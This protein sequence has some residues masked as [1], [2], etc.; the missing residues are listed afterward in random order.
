MSLNDVLDLPQFTALSIFKEDGDVFIHGELKGTDKT[1]PSC[2]LEA[3]KP[4]QYYEK[5][6]RHLPFANQ[7]TYLVFQRKDWICVCGKV[8]LER[9]AFQEMYAH[10]TVQYADY[11]YELAKKQDLKRVA[12]LEKLSW[13]VVEAIFLKGGPKKTESRERAGI[14]GSN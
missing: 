7:P 8:F 9:L 13:E 5:K 12:E 11:V 10:H 6:V 2:G 14:H 1:C 4:H 3:I